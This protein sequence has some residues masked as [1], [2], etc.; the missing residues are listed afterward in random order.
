MVFRKDERAGE[1]IIDHRESP[2]LTEA[3][4]RRGRALGMLPFLGKGQVFEGL[5]DTCSHCQRVVVRNPLR[6]RSRGYCSKCD[7]FLCDNCAVTLHLTGIC[8]PWKK[9]LADEAERVA[10]QGLIT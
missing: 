3:D 6:S 8:Y 9:R 2:G 10:R 4:A 1:V 7:R 5:T